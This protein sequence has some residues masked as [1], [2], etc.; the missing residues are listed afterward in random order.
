MN[1]EI[2]NFALQNGVNP[3]TLTSAVNTAEL[4][5]R[6]NFS[7]MGDPQN[8]G[9]VA[10]ACG[11]PAD[12]VAKAVNYSIQAANACAQCAPTQ[13]NFAALSQNFSNV[14]GNLI[15]SYSS[16]RNFD[17]AVAEG[18]AVK[19]AAPAEDDVMMIAQLLTLIDHKNLDEDP[20]GVANTVA[21]ATGV[22]I[23]TVKAM[24]DNAKQQFSLGNEFYIDDSMIVNFASLGYPA[25]FSEE[26]QAAAIEDGAEG[27]EPMAEAA[28]AEA[29]AAEG[30]MPPQG[31][32]PAGPMGI[33][34]ELPPQMSVSPDDSMMPQPMMQPQ[35][36][37]V[38]TTQNV[39][40][41]NDIAINSALQPMEP[42]PLPIVDP[43]SGVPQHLAPLAGVQ[44]AIKM[45]QDMATVDAMPNPGATAGLQNVD[46]GQTNF[47]SQPVL[48]RLLGDRYI[49]NGTK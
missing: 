8:I 21:N 30:Q 17:A 25:Y 36:I 23:E 49:P 43:N 20:E 9:I 41:T 6:L 12:F 37:P 16:S 44:N 26:E 45:Q 11:C 29:A 18:E 28:A 32:P 4:V 48:Q 46:P 24:V 15:M 35:A 34:V 1:P 39:A 2:Y 33:P 47:S 27:A 22:P 38:G 31:M 42:M 5:Q 7:E 40:T 19:E 13:Q 10:E 3:E 14:L